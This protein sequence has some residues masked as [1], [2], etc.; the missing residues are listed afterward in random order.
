MIRP[1]RQMMNAAADVDRI[2]ADPTRFPLRHVVSLSKDTII[3]SVWARMVSHLRVT[4]PE[5][6]QCDDDRE[7]FGMCLIRTRWICAT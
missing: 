2:V 7:A 1:V 6:Y 3:N 5:T 4:I